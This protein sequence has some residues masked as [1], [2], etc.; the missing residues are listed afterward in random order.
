MKWSSVNTISKL[1]VCDLAPL[2]C[3]ATLLLEPKIQSAHHDH[4]QSQTHELSRVCEVYKTKWTLLNVSVGGGVLVCHV[5]TV[6]TL[7][8][9]HESTR[10]RHTRI[11]EDRSQANRLAF[12]TS[13]LAFEIEQENIFDKVKSVLATGQVESG[14]RDDALL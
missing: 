12:D 11:T 9:W 6:L 1:R 3:E 4:S 5:N 2:P 7:C 8:L 13:N 14:S 10:H